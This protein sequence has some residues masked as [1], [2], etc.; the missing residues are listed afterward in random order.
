MVSIKNNAIL[1]LF[2]ESDHIVI[3]FRRLPT[4]YSFE[5]LSVILRNIHISCA[6][7]YSTSKYDVFHARAKKLVGDMHS[8]KR[9]E[10]IYLDRLRAHFMPLDVKVQGIED[11]IKQSMAMSLGERGITLDLAY[12]ELDLLKRELEN[13][14]DTKRLQ[15]L[16]LRYNKQKQ[17][18]KQAKQW[19]LIQREAMGMMNK[20]TLEL[21]NELYPDPDPPKSSEDSKIGSLIQEVVNWRK[22]GLL[23]VDK[24][25]DLNEYLRKTRFDVYL[26]S[27]LRRSAKIQD[28]NFE[29]SSKFFPDKQKEKSEMLCNEVL[30]ILRVEMADEGKLNREQEEFRME[31]VRD[32][33]SYLLQ[34]APDDPLGAIM[35]RTEMQL[36]QLRLGW[37]RPL[38]KSARPCFVLSSPGIQTKLKGRGIILSDK[39]RST[40]NLFGES[41][42][43]E[44]GSTCFPEEFFGRC[45]RSETN[46]QSI[47]SI[48]HGKPI[49][50]P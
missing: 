21:I 26:E 12:L 23:V 45:F 34:N 27:V 1:V 9:G 22:N 18:A 48:L 32:S 7:Y 31:W 5:A 11:E 41:I 33:L 47:E 29:F 19:L 8:T 3:M 50:M 42:H 4:L 40:F 39:S 37:K 14:R 49:T 6:H 16:I 30:Q 25:V 44:I 2:R 43:G 15:E 38:G 36:Q 28:K 13:E 10:N 35:K 24:D 20:P 46:L 17:F